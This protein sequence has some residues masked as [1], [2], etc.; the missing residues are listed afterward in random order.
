M[1]VVFMGKMRSTPWPKLILRT[2]KLACAPEVFL[3]TTPSN[4]CR[5]SLSPSLILTCTR[6]LSPG[7]K[8]GCV[9]CTLAMNF[10]MIGDDI[11]LFLVHL[12]QAQDLLNSQGPKCV[13]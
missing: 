6:T 7:L 4:A 12:R 5:R 9:R 1:T 10:V 11:V 13:R 3:I 8:L 2:V